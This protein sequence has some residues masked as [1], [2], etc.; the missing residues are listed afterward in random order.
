MRLWL[1]RTANVKQALAWLRKF[2]VA[3]CVTACCQVCYSADVVLL[4]K[5]DGPSLSS[6]RA[7]VAAGFYG[8]R[9]TVFHLKD[10]SDDLPAIK[11]AEQNSTVAVIITADV[12]HAINSAHLLSAIRRENGHSIPI[13]IDGITTETGAEDLRQWSGGAVSGC[14]GPVSITEQS[15]Y[16]ISTIQEVTRQLSG[17][18]LSARTGQTC[19]LI[20]DGSR[21]ESVIDLSS[22]TDE[23]PVFVKADVGAARVFLSSDVALAHVEPPPSAL[24]ESLY[25]FSEVAPAMMF[26]RYAAGDRAWHANGHYANL[27]VDD[28]WLREPYGYLQYSDLLQEMRR[29]NF[30]TTIAFIPWNYDRSE[31]DVISLFRA[32]SD[33]LSICIHGNNHDHQEFGPL[34]GRPLDAQVNNIR[35]ALARMEQFRKLTGLPYDR[36]MVFPHSIGSEA[37]IGA[38]KG[39]NFL[40]TAN[41][42]NIPLDS[43]VALDSQFGL[44]SWTLAFRNFLSF[45]RYSAEIPIAMSEV[46]VDVFLENPLLFYV[47]P[48]YFAEGIGRFD[49]MADT[50]NQLQPGT[51]W[52]GIADISDHLYLE[53]MRD[54]GNFDIQAFSSSLRINNVHRKDALFYVEKD[55]DFHF[56][57]EL[58]VD[59]LPYNYTRI[60]ARIAF[61]LP[62]G[63]GMSRQVT[64]RYQNGLDLKSVNISKSSLRVAVLRHL[65]DFRDDVVSRSRIGRTFI[66][67]Y[68]DHEE[69]ANVGIATVLM[70]LFFTLLVIGWRTWRTPHPNREQRLE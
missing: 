14:Q 37:V 10:R 2:L 39:F 64:C 66:R 59:G 29:H 69:Q 60:G 15:V 16:R 5:G 42:R 33:R 52:R 45:R 43:H 35:Q 38:L 12:L 13:L 30:H 21:A 20:V 8:L 11:A 32:N 17:Q 58:L 54:D 61:T 36:V 9:T 51:L 19:A 46:A 47:H 44:R 26:L 50:V 34:A 56:P 18:K 57:L 25:E 3:C 28:A 22:V 27:T 6:Q 70:V 31:P 48:A 4:E 67:V 41:S 49:T 62:V 53:K 63:A 1:L 23:K 65:S 24:D 68:T 55:E 7:A 40:A